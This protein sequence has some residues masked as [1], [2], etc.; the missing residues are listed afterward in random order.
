M[1]PPVGEKKP[2]L[3][4][5]QMPVG[6]GALIV[7][8]GVMLVFIGIMVTQSAGLIE[9]PD[10]SEYDYDEMVGQNLHTIQSESL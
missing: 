10:S 4:K 7:I 6:V 8:I 3:S 1:F 2:P 9:E 5:L